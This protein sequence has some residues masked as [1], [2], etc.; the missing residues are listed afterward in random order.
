VRQAC[1][2]NC[3]E[4]LRLHTGRC[5]RDSAAAVSRRARREPRDQLAH[6]IQPRS[7]EG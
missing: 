7:P 2:D 3:S 1:A 6:A 5:G 4:R